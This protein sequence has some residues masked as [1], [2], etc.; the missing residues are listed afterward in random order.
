MNAFTRAT[1]AISSVLPFRSAKAKPNRAEDALVPEVSVSSDEARGEGTRIS[2]L[3][4]IED[5]AQIGD[6]CEIGPWCVVGSD[7]VLGPGN[8]LLSHVVITGRTVVGRDNVFH[9]FCVIGDTP[10]DYK[11]RGERTGVQIGSRN[12]IREHVTVHAGTEYGGRVNG[13]G[14]TR[15]GDDN[16]LMVNAHVGHDV[17]MANRCTIANNVMLAGHIVLGNSV[18]L[19]GAV[20]VNPFVTLHDF[21]YA[22]AYS[23]IHH[24]VPPFMK[25]SGC[26]EVR[27]LNSIGLQRSGKFSAH[28]VEILEMAARHLFG[29]KK[30]RSVAIEEL[31]R[32]AMASSN[33]SPAAAVSTNGDSID[34]GELARNAHVRRLV[35]A[36][37][38]RDLGKHGRFL[39]SLRK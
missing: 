12:L 7:V 18:W 14:I 9:P 34:L 8:K 23:Q 6:D 35:E 32:A 1:D 19:N 17:Q 2:P 25:V 13:G 22:A 28:D 24:D 3:A 15:V 37:K 4:V 27:E 39:E 38:Q 16:M 29:R 5:G 21:S 20:G 33:G 11:F 31:E 30:P 26:D 10:Q 36:L